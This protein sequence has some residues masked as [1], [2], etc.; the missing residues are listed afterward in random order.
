MKTGMARLG[1]VTAGYPWP[2]AAKTAAVADDRY[3]TRPRQ[4]DP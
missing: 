4:L 3:L 2:L 1:W